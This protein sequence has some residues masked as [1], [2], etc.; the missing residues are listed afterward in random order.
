MLH[1]LKILPETNIW[2]CAHIDQGMEMKIGGVWWYEH[3]KECAKFQL[4]WILLAST[5][6]N[7]ASMWQKLWKIAEEDSLG[8]WSWIL[9]W[10]NYL[11]VKSCQTFWDQS[12]NA[13]WYFLHRRP[14]WTEMKNEY[15]WIIFGLEQESLDI[16][17]AYMIQ[18]IFEN[19]LGILWKTKL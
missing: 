2:R 18:T 8:K 19:N 7:K 13:R 5:S 16:F 4:I 11:D 12:R 17:G 9:A 10:G 6:F 14:L 15:W 1:N 3:M